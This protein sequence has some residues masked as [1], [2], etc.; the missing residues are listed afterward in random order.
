M[1]DKN[2]RLKNKNHER[3]CQE[4][5]KNRN[6]GKKA[7]TIVYGKKKT[8]QVAEVNASRLLSNAKIKKRIDELMIKI[9]EKTLVTPERIIKEYARIAFLDVRKLFDED[10]K[11][12]KITEL[13]DDTAAAVAG[14]D[15]S[16]FTKL[17][18]EE[19]G[20]IL[21]IV[22]KI[23]N[24]DKK[25]ALD[26]LARINSMFSDTL[27]VEHTFEDWLKEEMSKK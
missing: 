6:N 25:G 10:G 23:K 27:K 16:T 1:D 26:S 18:N 22:K 5:I 15:I 17:G 19:Q 2:K 9:E 11:L 21:E 12:K 8:E 24:V 14:M 20:T 7:Y 4:Y 13:D 3:F